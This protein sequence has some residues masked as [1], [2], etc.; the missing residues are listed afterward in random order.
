MANSNQYLPV[1]RSGFTGPSARIG[2]SSDYHID[3]K[4]LDRLPVQEKIRALDSLARQYQSIGRDIEF[5]NEG[6]S[7]RRWNLGAT[8]QEKEALLQ[9]AASAHAPRSGWTS[10]DFYV[11]FKGKDRFA[12][13]AVEGASIYVPGVPG[14]KIQRGSGGGYGY[15]SEVM[16]PSGRVVFRVGHGD[17]DRPE[18]QQEILVQDSGPT[19]TTQ[20]TQAPAN[21][22]A[23][24]TAFLGTMLANML[25]KQQAAGTQPGMTPSEKAAAGL[26]SDKA[27]QSQELQKTIKEA[28]AERTRAK[29]EQQEL[30]E[31]AYLYQQGQ[32]AIGATKER[33]ANLLASAQK[34]FSPG[35]PVF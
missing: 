6:V 28:L 4:I 17:I 5:S 29:K 7:G 32:K 21:N 30:E 13:G 16:D 25:G 24:T 27:S 31:R 23:F 26:D 1:Y 22:D 8:P 33:M 12:E 19:G 34:A 2:G 35:K 18:E 3:L 15:F 11:P 20:T 10:L 9:A 14:G